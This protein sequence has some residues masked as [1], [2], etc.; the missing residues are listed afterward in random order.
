[1]KT[2]RCKKFYF[3]RDLSNNSYLIN[4]YRE[5][6]AKKIRELIENENLDYVFKGKRLDQGQIMKR[7]IHTVWKIYLLKGGGKKK[8]KSGKKL[9]RWFQ[10]IYMYTVQVIG[11]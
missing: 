9:Q 5:W 1:M 2:E 7:G 10:R 6:E 3:I 11:L 4:I 8:K